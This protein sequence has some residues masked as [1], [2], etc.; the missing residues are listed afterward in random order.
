MTKDE[1]ILK[2]DEQIAELKEK[3]YE[4]EEIIYEYE[5]NDMGAVVSETEQI[6]LKVIHQQIEKLAFISKD[7]KLDKD[8][9]KNFDTFVKDLVA[10]RGKMPTP[11]TKK[12]ADE[13]DDSIA[14]LIALATGE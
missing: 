11:K 1:L 4:L 5:E 14:D 2:R 12:V 10:I 6:A 8:E 13:S 9:A 3:I 7:D